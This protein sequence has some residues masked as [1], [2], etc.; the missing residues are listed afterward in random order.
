VEGSAV[1]VLNLEPVD[2]VDVTT[3]VDNTADMLLPDVGPVRR[4]GLSGTSGPLPVAP[5]GVSFGGSTLDFLRAEHGYS[6][7][8]DVYQ[9]GRMHRVL[10]DAGVSPFGLVENLDRLGISPHTFQAIVLSHGH[11]DHVAG[12]HG[13]I[14]RTGVRKLPVLLHPDF[15]TR[16]RIAS[17]DRFIDLPTPS[18]AAIEDAGFALIED[19]QP[20]FLLGGVLLVTGEVPRTTAFETGLPAGHQAWVEG[21]WRHDP[22]VHEDQALVAHVHGRGLVVITGCGHA[23]IVNI[24]RQAKRL[25]GVDQIHLVTGGLHLR[26]GPRLAETVAALTEERPQLIVA[27]HCTSWLAHHALYEAMP[28]AY[29]PNSVGSRFELRAAPEMSVS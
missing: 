22:L 4:W 9:G 3:L 10:Y 27:A 26:D 8:V 7:L 1:T 29:R 12:I 20:S 18:R 11:F 23:G 5:S 21:Q 14:K 16:R 15:W 25:T 6:A 17:P 13:L 24:V 19:R 28:Q 2:R